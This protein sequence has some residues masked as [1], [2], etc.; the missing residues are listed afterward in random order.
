MSIHRAQKVY[1]T[2]RSGG[3]VSDDDLEFGILYYGE[4]SI[5]LFNCGPVFRLAAQ[6]ANNIL[7]TLSNFQTAR[8]GQV[9]CH[10]EHN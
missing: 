6:E 4:L 9:T 2:V 3:P 5:N 7:Y 8:K 10:A 1:E